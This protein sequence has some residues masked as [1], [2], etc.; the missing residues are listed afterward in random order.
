MC[1]TKHLN[2]VVCS[3]REVCERSQVFSFLKGAGLSTEIT[4]S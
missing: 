3:V 1:E 2:R 4:S